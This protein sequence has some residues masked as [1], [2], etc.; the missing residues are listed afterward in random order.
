MP[1]KLICCVCLFVPAISMA[2]SDKE[3]NEIKSHFGERKRQIL[4][5]Q[6]ANP[7]PAYQGHAQEPMRYAFNRLNYALACL[8][9]DENIEQA[10]DAV[11]NAIEK[12]TAPDNSSHYFLGE[13]GLHW[14]G[15]VLGRIYLLFGNNGLIQERLSENTQAIV[16]N[17]IWQWA[18]NNDWH[19]D[20]ADIEQDIWNI[21][22]SENHDIMRGSL[23]WMIAKIL[24]DSP[25]YQDNT[26]SS[27][28]SVK[29]FHKK[30]IELSG[31][32]KVEIVPRVKYEHWDKY[33]TVYLSE[34]GKRGL[35]AEI[36]SPGYA[37]HTLQCLYNLYD[38]ADSGSEVKRLAK[39]LLDL[40]WADW[41]SE[42][43]DACRGGSKVR[44]ARGGGLYA[45]G[46]SQSGLYQSG[47]LYSWIYTG[48][49]EQASLN[50]CVMPAAT[51]DYMIPDV[52]IDIAL[53]VEGRGK[54][55]TISRRP[56]ANKQPRPESV[57]TYN[58]TRIY[59]LNPDWNGKVKYSYCT[60]SF[61]MGCDFSP[62]TH[63]SD[64][65]GWGQN[66]WA[67]IM[68]SGNPDDLIYPEA[69]TDKGERGFT[70]NQHWAVQNKNTM[71]L[72]RNKYGWLVGD[73]RLWF[74]KNLERYE[75]E[76]WIFVKAQKAYAAVKVAFGGY[77][78]DD[79]N[80]LRLSD[81]DSPIIFEAA[82]KED[83]SDFDAFKEDVLGNKL[84][85]Q[86]EAT[87]KDVP[88]TGAFAMRNDVLYYEGIL[89]SGNFT[90]YFRSDRTP[91]INNIPI[92]YAPDFTFK[93]PFI[94]QYPYASDKVVIQ[95][96]GRQIKL[97]F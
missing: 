28:K 56:S 92:N 70:Y 66:L 17:A 43:I 47:R 9:L 39:A 12:L 30:N 11:V 36:D 84:V 52:V 80:W 51:S 55:E 35:F 94:N 14:Q 32:D 86:G 69:L 53:D 77:T 29:T 50:H 82:C 89:D 59:P 68:F 26:Y 87:S 49:G 65:Y 88:E 79:E 7:E 48:L 20:P 62:K 40:W 8:Y 96:D 16:K 33:F 74:G 27:D 67:G 13:A 90:F 44:C 41:A 73:M 83:Y 54:Y 72:Q 57:G 31:S 22:E 23:C 93:S 63:Y 71:I 95:K 24:K 78:W 4:T 37:K 46:A 6:I 25:D 76:G 10:N 42:Q 61:I 2:L 75:S 34:R 3:I 18:Y 45:L 38:F 97:E 60:P 64:W 85:I 21:W 5:S 15:S 81:I 91:E 58:Q 1:T 19:F